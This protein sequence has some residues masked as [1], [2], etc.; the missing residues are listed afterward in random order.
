M[1]HWI[2]DEGDDEEPGEMEDGE[3]LAIQ[4]HYEYRWALLNPSPLPLGLK[5]YAFPHAPF[6][7]LK[8]VLTAIGYTIKPWKFLAS[9]SSKWSL[10]PKW[11]IEKSEVVE[12]SHS[13]STS[14]SAN[15]ANSELIF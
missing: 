14:H 7:V 1:A 9:W 12:S 3:H 2:A 10:L 11:K 8:Y 6:W 15:F 5:F 13:H 4:H